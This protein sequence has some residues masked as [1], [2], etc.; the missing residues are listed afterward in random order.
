MEKKKYRYN[1]STLSFETIEVTAYK[2]FANVLIPFVYSLVIALIVFF[3]YNHFFDTPKEKILKRENAEIAL[4]F[5][6]F[7]KKLKDANLL[8]EDIQKRDNL[9][10]RAIFDADTI[11]NALRMG[12][13]GG[14]SRY[15]DL[16]EFSKSDLII[17][18][19]SMLDQVTWKTYIQSKSFDE[20]VGLA[21]NKEQMILRIPAIQPVSVA[22]LTRISDYFGYRRDPFKRNRKFHQGMDFAG[23][24]GSPI[25]ATGNGRVISAKYSYFGYG[26]NIII[27]HGFGYKTRYA[28]L[29]AI[30]VKVGDTVTRGQVIGELGNSGRSTGPH[31]HYEVIYRNKVVDPLNYFNDMKPEEYDMMVKK[32]NAPDSLQVGS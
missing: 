20:V 8:L 22:D 25:Y 30:S 4:K 16:R 11:P 18:V 13:M 2:K 9:T 1:P 23:P 5:E 31:L 24:K 6:M 7:E 28:H 32:A 3:T 27:D 14:A 21:K 19:A 29:N 17:S 26:N 15:D 10:Y 12:G